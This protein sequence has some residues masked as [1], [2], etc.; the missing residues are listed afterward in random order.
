MLQKKKKKKKRQHIWWFYTSG[1]PP[2]TGFPNIISHP[3]AM[4]KEKENEKEDE[5]KSTPSDAQ[6]RRSI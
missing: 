4:G 2:F 6:S 3:N 5:K 1:L